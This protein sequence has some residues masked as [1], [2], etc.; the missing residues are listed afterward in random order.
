MEE[1]E[2]A[3]EEMAMMDLE[4][5]SCPSTKYGKEVSRK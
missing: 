2:E 4:M 5:V 1:D 3:M